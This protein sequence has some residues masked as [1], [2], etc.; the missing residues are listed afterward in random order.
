MFGQYSV[1]W[2]QAVPEIAGL[3]VLIAMVRRWDRYR[4]RW[5]FEEDTPFS[6][7]SLMWALA[8]FACVTAGDQLIA[9]AMPLE[10][11]VIVG[12]SAADGIEGAL[13]ATA[14]AVVAAP[15]LEELG[16]R[17]LLFSAVRRYLNAPMAVALTACVFAA[18]HVGYDG[19]DVA[20]VLWF[21]I[22]MALGYE[23]S[24]SVW[25]LV[26]CHAVYNAGQVMTPWV[27]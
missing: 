23:L 26:I 19:P 2:A 14:V 4:W 5:W 1:A 11:I 18:A 10:P 9:F 6:S 20:L 24:G 3:V 17:G 25:P 27:W 7:K 21:G 8:L 16:F 15:L 12:E 13:V 22:A